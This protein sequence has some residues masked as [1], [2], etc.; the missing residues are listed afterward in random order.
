MSKVISSFCSADKPQCV[1]VEALGNGDVFVTDSKGSEFHGLQFTRAEWEAF[2][3]G[4]KQGEFDY[5]VLS[6]LHG[7][8]VRAITRAVRR[9]RPVSA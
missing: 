7:Q 8:S 3:A 2:I 5:S 1:E 4:A 6:S 9:Q